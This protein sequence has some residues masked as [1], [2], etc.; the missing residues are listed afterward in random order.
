MVQLLWKTVWWILKKLSIELPNDPAVLLLGVQPG[1]LKAGDQ[2]G[3]CT[4]G[5]YSQ[6][7]HQQMNG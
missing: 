6:P 5:I 3:A 1:E 2:P 7:I 4:E